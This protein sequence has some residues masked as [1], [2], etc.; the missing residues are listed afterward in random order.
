MYSIKVYYYSLFYLTK[1]TTASQINICGSAVRLNIRH[2]LSDCCGLI[3]I[4]FY[5]LHVIQPSDRFPLITLIISAWTDHRHA[6]P[7]HVDTK[8]F[9]AGRIQI[10]KNL[11][12]NNC[13]GRT[14]SVAVHSVDSALAVM[15]VTGHHIY[16]PMNYDVAIN[17]VLQ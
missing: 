14:D 6:R 1:T 10:L 17:W 3:N 8:E 4:S 7:D 16:I 15:T 12:E 13:S 11:A 9:S 5:C 2:L